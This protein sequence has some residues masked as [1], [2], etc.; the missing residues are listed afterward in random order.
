MKIRAMRAEF[1]HVNGRT[2]MQTKRHEEANRRY[3]QFCERP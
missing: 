2:D 3:S 1:F